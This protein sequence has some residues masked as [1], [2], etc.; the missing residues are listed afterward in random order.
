MYIN[1]CV[2]CSIHCRWFKC[3]YE[4]YN[5]EKKLLPQYYKLANSNAVVNFFSSSLTLLLYTY[6]AYFVRRRTDVSKAAKLLLKKWM[7]I[8]A[9]LWIY[10]Y[11]C[12]VNLFDTILYEVEE[13][14]NEEKSYKTDRLTCILYTILHNITFI[15]CTVY[16]IYIYILMR[17]V[18]LQFSYYVLR[19]RSAHKNRFLTFLHICGNKFFYPLIYCSF[20]IRSMIF[21]FFLAAK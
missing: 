17:C 15:H 2:R 21:S 5:E 14:I 13:E 4:M 6:V 1:D 10:D 7:L 12:N 3:V 11:V 9:A 20:D 19:Y 8:V 18:I 16:D